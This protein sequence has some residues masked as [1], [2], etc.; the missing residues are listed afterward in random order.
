M[1]RLQVFYINF[2][3]GGDRMEPSYLVDLRSF[4]LGTVRTRIRHSTAIKDLR[5]IQAFSI[6]IYPPL[7]LEVVNYATLE[8]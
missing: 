4:E 7:C 6:G 3:L 1:S 8:T 5:I 2:K